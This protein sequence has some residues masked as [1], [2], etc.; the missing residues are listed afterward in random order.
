MARSAVLTSH[1]SA[2]LLY[3]ASKGERQREAIEL[4]NSRCPFVARL[5]FIASSS[6]RLEVA[7]GLGVASRA[8]RRCTQTHVSATAEAWVAGRRS[9]GSIVR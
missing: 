1:V 4:H 2:D 6:G 7:G 3:S 9:R 5:S 8:R